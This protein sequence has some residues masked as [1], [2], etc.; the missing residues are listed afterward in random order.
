MENLLLIS[1]VV[2]VVGMS[3]LF[4]ALAILYGLIYLMTTVLRDP[5]EARSDGF[6]RPIATEVAT[7]NETGERDLALR[8]AAVAVALAR[9]G[10]ELSPIGA[11]PPAEAGDSGS[12]S[13]WWALHH[14]RQLAGGRIARRP[15]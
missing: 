9:A 6:S 7:T 13:R 11:P 1:L 14:S 4:L 8:A 15:Q 10:Q 3:L 12:G 2:S 5:E